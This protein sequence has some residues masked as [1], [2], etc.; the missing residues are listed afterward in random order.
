ML[1]AKCVDEHFALSPRDEGQFKKLLGNV[2]IALVFVSTPNHPWTDTS[3]ND[4]FKVVYS[5]MEVIE[6][7]A[8]RYGAPL[9]LDLVY[10][11]YDSP[12][13]YSYEDWTDL[14]W[15]DY[16]MKNYFYSDSFSNL[17][18]K[19]EKT[20]KKDSYPL[21]FMFN[22]YSR[23]FSFIADKKSPLQNELN[24]YFCDKSLLH[25]NFLT[26]EFLHLYGAIDL[27]D[28]NEGEGIEEISKHYFP[29]SVMQDGKNRSIDELNAYL[30]GWLD[31]PTTNIL[32]FFSET[33]GIR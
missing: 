1:I 22:S 8:S 4:L 27:Y 5:S 3:K 18:Y 19:L 26:H 10:F 24:I 25:S 17:I 15:F 29:E 33:E 12:Y 21:L 28:Y 32:Q 2:E 20:Y 11:E 31:Y 16:G 30:I 9:S 14:R 6:S 7:E 23:S 13:D